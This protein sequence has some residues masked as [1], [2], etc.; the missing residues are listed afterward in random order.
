[1]PLGSSILQLISLLQ[2]WLWFS[3][4]FVPPTFALW[5][6]SV[7]KASLFTIFYAVIN[8]HIFNMYFNFFIVNENIHILELQIRLCYTPKLTH[9]RICNG[10]TLSYCHVNLILFEAQ[11][12]VSLFFLFLF[13]FLNS[14]NRTLVRKFTVFLL[15]MCI[16]VCMCVNLR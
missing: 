9:W 12:K 11:A 10:F 6:F 1:M 2:W 3:I 16:S 7:R 13:Q 14:W 4:S 5:N 15:V 8:L